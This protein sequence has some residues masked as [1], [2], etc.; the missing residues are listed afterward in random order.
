MQIHW[1]PGH[2]A[3]SRKLM[4]ER[5]K[6][7]DLAIELADAR[8]P[9]SSRNPD[10]NDLLGN[11]PRLLLLTKADLADHCATKAWCRHYQQTGFITLAADLL[12]GTH[13]T[14]I[15][16]AIDKLA[17]RVMDEMME[18]GKLRRPA[19]VMVVGIPNV[20][21][22]LLVN[23]LS[24]MAATQVENRPGVTRG[25]QWVRVWKHLELM[26]TP[27]MLW[28]KIEDRQTAIKLALVGAIRQEILDS[29]ELAVIFLRLVLVNYP[30]CL[31][32]RYGK[33]L[34]AVTDPILALERIGQSRRLLK[35]GGIVDVE[36]AAEVLLQE[37]RTGKLGKFSLERIEN[38]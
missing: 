6:L 37:F 32:E 26:D 7:V 5:L 8:I 16:N 3:K 29:V 35:K 30:Q 24:G 12:S 38:R 20:G 4:K 27:G 34:E 11:K 9:V 28:P 31:N 33:L 13:L 1:Y 14:G 18:A 17:E 23:R 36:K 15:L 2:M 19:R 22:S 21:K 10:L 25:Y